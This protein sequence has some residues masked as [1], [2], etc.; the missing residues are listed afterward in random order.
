MVWWVEQSP[1]AVPFDGLY[2][3]P[4]YMTKYIVCVYG[5]AGGS[6]PEKNT[7]NPLHSILE[8]ARHTFKHIPSCRSQL[9][10]PYIVIRIE[11]H[12]CGQEEPTSNPVIQWFQSLS[13]WVIEGL[14]NDRVLVGPTRGR[15]STLPCH[16]SYGC[17]CRVDGSW[18][19]KVD[20]GEAK[21]ASSSTSGSV[22]FDTRRC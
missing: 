1:M 4:K 6:Q 11:R 15:E 2:F 3:V 22:F 20:D 5:G 9:L 17:V 14:R 8:L 18:H 19:R 7:R 12:Q 16:R 13:K 21:I 10:G